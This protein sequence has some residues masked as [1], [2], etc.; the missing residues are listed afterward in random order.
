MYGLNAPVSGPPNS[1]Q[2]NPPSAGM[3]HQEGGGLV[4]RV[5]DCLRD[6]GELRSLRPHP[7]SE[8]REEN[9]LIRERPLSDY[10]FASV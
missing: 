8:G 7:S 1:Q 10:R 5:S 9:G 3:R 4:N 2:L 6:T